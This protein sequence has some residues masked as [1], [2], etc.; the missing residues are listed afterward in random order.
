MFIRS[1]AILILAVMALAVCISVQPT[2]F[3]ISRTT[4]FAAPVNVVFAQVNNLRNW[5]NWSPWARL[6]PSA[7]IT[8]SG[9][10]FGVGSSMHWAGNSN[11]GEGTMTL[12]QSAPDKQISFDLA[13][14]EPLSGKSVATFDFKPIAGLTE[15]TWTMRG[16]NNFVGKAVTLFMNC[17]KMLGGQFEQG[18]ANLRAIVEKKDFSAP[19]TNL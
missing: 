9:P 13:F 18:F 1:L 6:D 14:Q 16:T 3:V 5:N 11:I 8:Y 2:D 19:A 12:T 7:K 4:T 17:E 15:V 10:A